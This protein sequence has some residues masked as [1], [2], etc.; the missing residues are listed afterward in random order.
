MDDDDPFT[1]DARMYVQATRV[2]TCIGRWQSAG[3]LSLLQ[4]AEMPLIAVD[5]PFPCERTCCAAPGGGQLAPEDGDLRSGPACSASPS[6]ASAA[7]C[8]SDGVAFCLLH[9]SSSRSSSVLFFPT[10]CRTHKA[11]SHSAHVCTGRYYQIPTYNK[12]RRKHPPTLLCT[13][14]STKARGVPATGARKRGE[15]LEMQQNDLEAVGWPQKPAGT[16]RQR[17][18]VAALSLP[19]CRFT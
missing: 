18:P 10:A 19:Q 3:M 15:G 5:S 11:K 4:S 9:S 13:K 16:K 1:D 6:S 12:Q 14:N 7:R 2:H 17:A 8:C